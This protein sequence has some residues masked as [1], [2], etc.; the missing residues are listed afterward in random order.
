MPTDDPLRSLIRE[1]PD[2]PTPGVSFKD[3]TPLLAD[4]AAFDGA[5]DRLAG[6]FS[7]DGVTHVVGIEARGFVLAAP[8]AVRLGAGFVPARK[9]GKLPW[10]TKAQAYDL[11]YGTDELQIHTDAV[12]PGDRV[13]IVDDVLATGGTAAAALA[14]VEATGVDVV[15]I[16]FLLELG[17]LG[18]ASRLPAGRHTSLLTYDS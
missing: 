14:L 11:E 13:L 16:G 15:G 1:V 6:H 3:I 4:A 12:T 2:W 17:F 5:V 9:P 7:D 8:I 10:S 18:G